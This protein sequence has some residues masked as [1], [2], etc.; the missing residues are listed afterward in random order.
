MDTMLETLDSFPCDLRNLSLPVVAGG[1][2]YCVALWM[3]HRFREPVMQA[4]HAVWSLGG[5][6]GPFIIARFLVELPPSAS[7]VVNGSR[8]S[9]DPPVNN[10]VEPGNCS[11][12][13]V[14]VNYVNTMPTCRL[15]MPWEFLYVSYLVQDASFS[16]L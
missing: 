2:S 11:T 8:W 6:I 12:R 4:S 7:S 5:T 14:A 1:Q 13:N 10:S 9:M 16:V 3:G 15:S